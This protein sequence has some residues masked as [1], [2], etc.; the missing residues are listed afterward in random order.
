MTQRLPDTFVAYQQHPSP[1]GLRAIIDEHKKFID[2]T[3]HN[4]I[5]QASPVIQTRA[6][7]MAADSVRKYDPSKGV[8]LKNWIAQGLQGLRSLN[9]GITEV[10]SVPEKLRRKAAIVA[11]TRDEL[12]ESLNREPSYEELA[13]ATGV[14]VK[15]QQ[16]MLR[17]A[18]WSKAE[19]SLLAN[20][21]AGDDEASDNTPSLKKDPQEE[22]RDYVYH[23]L[24]DVDKQIFRGRMGYGGDPIA[25]NQ[26]IAA[27][28]NLTPSAVSQRAN[29]IQKRL[30]GATWQ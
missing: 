9:R 28:L 25:P 15:H 26:E 3:V 6:Y 19:G 17:G 20:L 30:E 7:L 11:R 24:D 8:P 27:K 23:D 5:G 21:E 16:R 2:G 22:I 1:Q 13:D 10:I 12:R 14:P 18:L 4:L 29:R